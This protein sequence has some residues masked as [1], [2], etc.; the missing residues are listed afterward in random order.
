MKLCSLLFYGSPDTYMEQNSHKFPGLF[1][2]VDY[3]LFIR[4]WIDKDNS[5]VS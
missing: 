5:Y 4:K 2:T 1:K 3:S